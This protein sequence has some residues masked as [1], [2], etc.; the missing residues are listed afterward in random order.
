MPIQKGQELNRNGKNKTLNP[1]YTLDSNSNITLDKSL[2]GGEL[3]INDAFE[4]M[5]LSDLG[6]ENDGFSIFYKGKHLSL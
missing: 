2:I 3:I 1:V 5:D 4:I 6:A